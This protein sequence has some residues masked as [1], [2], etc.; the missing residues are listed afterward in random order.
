MKIKPEN[1]VRFYDR[2]VEDQHD[3]R[4][5]ERG[6]YHQT[7]PRQEQLRQ[8][9]RF[10]PDAVWFFVHNF[11]CAGAGMTRR[12]L[13]FRFQFET[14]HVVSCMFRSSKFPPARC[15]VSAGK[16]YARPEPAV[17]RGRPIS[18]NSASAF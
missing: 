14:P 9:K 7:Q 16:K 6:Y 18:A 11:F 12:W 1:F 5:N 2:L 8:V 17:P 15:A 4:E 10:F 13:L 3:A